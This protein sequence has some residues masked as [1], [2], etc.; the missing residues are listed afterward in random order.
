MT[1]GSILLIVI[2]L[3]LLYAIIYYISRDAQ[4]LSGSVM[5]GTVM[6]TIP[7][8]KLTSKQ[9]SSGN[10]SYSV[11]FNIDD[12][13]YRYGETKVIL[14]RSATA[15]T[16]TTGN[17]TSTSSSI[18]G[19]SPTIG[20]TTTSGSGGNIDVASLQPCPFVVLDTKANNL[21]VS[22]TCYSS[23]AAIPASGSVPLGIV[24]NVEI[25]NIP[26]Q[27]WTHL[28][29]SVYGRTLDIYIDGKLVRTGILPGTANVNPNAN[30]YLT[31]NG[32]FWGWTSKLQYWNNATDPQTV[33]NIYTKGYGQGI[34]GSLFGKYQLQ[35]SILTDNS[36][37]SQITI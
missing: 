34:F 23:S 9:G 21:I 12:W 10:F 3:V 30:L 2:V 37:T 22:V 14:G 29:V 24:H 36:T 27:R 25:T 18:S 35:L 20:S 13:N 15:L 6:T 7:A 19:A 8:S 31:P 33:W 28:F 32:G 1:V 26:I 11:W 5:D 16:G 4:T 17:T